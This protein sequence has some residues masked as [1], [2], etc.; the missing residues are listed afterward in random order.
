MH[1]GPF[2]KIKAA[3]RCQ[4]ASGVRT[5]VEILEAGISLFDSLRIPLPVPRG[6]SNPGWVVSAAA[7]SELV[8]IQDILHCLLSVAFGSRFGQVLLEYPWN[9]AH[10]ILHSV[11]WFV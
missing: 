10:G 11:A 3:A 2:V 6:D 9:I 4:P 7:V 1:L 5:T 8:A